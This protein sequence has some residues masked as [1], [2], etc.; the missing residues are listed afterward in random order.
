MRIQKLYLDAFGPF[1]NYSIDLSSGKEGLHFVYG[2]NEAGKSSALRAIS[3]LLFGIP[4]RSTDDFVHPHNSMCIGGTISDGVRTLNINRRKGNKGTLRNRDKDEILEESALDVF[5]GGMDKETF[6]IVFGLSHNNLVEGGRAIVE[7]KGNVG[8]ALFAASAGLGNLSKVK[9]NLIKEAEELFKPS[10]SKPL[11]NTSIS[12]LSEV[13]KNLKTS[14]LRPSD[15]SD[16]DKELH[17]AIESRILL[18]E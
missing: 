17:L 2:L 18:R 13:R 3:Q 16:K 12:K 6:E 1:T 15:W 5:L 7:G 10:G 4:P 14:Q 11:I 8:E 9:E